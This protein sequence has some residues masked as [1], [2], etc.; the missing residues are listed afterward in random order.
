M[1]NPGFSPESERYMI[2]HMNEEHADSN[3][4][5]AKVYGHLWSATAA[6]MVALDK[7]GMDLEV[8]LP[9]GAQR[10]RLPFDHPL[11]DE[12]D[13]QR[14]LVEMSLHAQETLTRKAKQR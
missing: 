12:G 4:M 13:A 3:L 9:G 7:G 5:Y 14:T 10:I 1:Q 2:A 11:A 6:R 8:T